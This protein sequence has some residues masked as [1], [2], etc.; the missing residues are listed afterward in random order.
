MRFAR[1]KAEIV[2]NSHSF[3]SKRTQA[4]YGKP[5]RHACAYLFGF[6]YLEHY[7]YALRML[8]M[9]VFSS[10]ETCAWL[11]WISSATSICV[12]P[13]KYRR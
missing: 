10:R 6:C 5:K 7:V 12:F 8:L 4:A 9:A 13:S 1:K 11:M 2:K 3:R